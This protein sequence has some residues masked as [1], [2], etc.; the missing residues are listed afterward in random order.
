[1]IANAK[2]RGVLSVIES[3]FTAAGSSRHLDS[4]LRSTKKAIHFGFEFVDMTESEVT[5][6]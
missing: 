2:N 6:R 5:F 1:L 3:G 4:A